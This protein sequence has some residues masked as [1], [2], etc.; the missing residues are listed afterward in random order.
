[1][2]LFITPRRQHLAQRH[3]PDVKNEVVTE[4]EIN[5]LSRTCF[6]GPAG[7]M[8]QPKPR[9]MLSCVTMTETRAQCVPTPTNSGETRSECVNSQTSQSGGRGRVRRARPGRSGRPAEGD[10]E[11]EEERGVGKEAGGRR[12]CQRRVRHSCCH[13]RGIV[14]GSD[15]SQRRVQW[16]L[17]RPDPVTGHLLT[18]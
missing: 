8:A 17:G 1:M 2:A 7:G 9:R 16:Q 14:C 15:T 13:H 10:R 11:L 18:T 3:F 12:R 4:T 6:V 5:H